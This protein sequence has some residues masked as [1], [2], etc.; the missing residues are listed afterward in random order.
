LSLSHRLGSA[1]ESVKIGR[2]LIDSSQHAFSC[3][4]VSEPR[5]S[6]SVEKKRLAE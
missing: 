6:D 2:C 5:L 4:C 1:R 3:Q